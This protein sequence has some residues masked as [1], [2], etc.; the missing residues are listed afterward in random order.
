MPPGTRVGRATNVFKPNRKPGGAAEMIKT[1][2][3]YVF[4]DLA[5]TVYLGVTL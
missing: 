4:Y 5:T 3:D 2:G 1:L